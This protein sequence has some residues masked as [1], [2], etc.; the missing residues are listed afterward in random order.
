MNLCFQRCMN[1][2]DVL[3]NSSSYTP[4]TAGLLPGD[5]LLRWHNLDPIETRNY[6]T[7]DV[8]SAVEVKIVCGSLNELPLHNTHSLLL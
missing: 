8:I 2:I 6:V 7:H 5:G 3:R 4:K 1:E